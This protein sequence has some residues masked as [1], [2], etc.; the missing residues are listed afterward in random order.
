MNAKEITIKNIEKN[1]FRI[2]KAVRGKGL[3]L[4]NANSYIIGVGGWA[5]DKLADRIKKAIKDYSFDDLYVKEI[6]IRID[7]V[8]KHFSFDNDSQTSRQKFNL[9]ELVASNFKDVIE[10]DIYAE[11]KELL[12]YFPISE[13]KS[14]LDSQKEMIENLYSFN[15]KTLFGDELYEYYDEL[16]Y[17]DD[18]MSFERHGDDEYWN[19]DY[20]LIHGD[21][22]CEDTGECE[23]VDGRIYGY[24][25]MVIDDFWNMELDEGLKPHLEEL[26]P[27]DDICVYARKGKD[28]YVGYTYES[29]QIFVSYLDEDKEEAEEELYAYYSKENIE[30]IAK[31]VSIL[32]SYR[33]DL[34]TRSF[35]YNEFGEEPEVADKNVINLLY[36]DPNDLREEVID[37][38][39]NWKPETIK[40]EFATQYNRITG[41]KVEIDSDLTVKVTYTPMQMVTDVQEPS[42]ERYNHLKILKRLEKR[43]GYELVHTSIS[44]DITTTAWALRKHGEEYHFELLPTIADDLNE[45]RTLR[46]FIVNALESLEKRKLEKIS[47]AELFKKAAFVFVGFEDSLKSGN[48]KFGTEQFIAK[49]HIDTNKIGGIRG[50]ILLDIELSSYTKR[51]VNQ[52]MIVHG[53]VA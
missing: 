25:E 41:K 31:V 51:A 27:N 48:C 2:G 7:D 21:G 14:D 32:K 52:A 24:N 3:E 12:G 10:I 47:Q 16:D 50:D 40:E 39:S 26:D 33:D 45:E 49:H 20:H 23:Y 37:S 19:G 30:L 34:K 15:G 13:Y 11:H 5:S 36:E 1:G 43:F 35:I 42:V 44:G 29:E 8:K 9:K 28:W 53:G 38:I 6:W 17:N 46:E 4:F 22:Y 18:V